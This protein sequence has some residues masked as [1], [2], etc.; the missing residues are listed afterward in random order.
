[1]LL[2]ELVLE[3]QS[4]RPA[5]LEKPKAMQLAAHSRSHSHLVARVLA[6]EKDNSK[7]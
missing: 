4:L 7:E 1:M 2:L 3:S 6:V 5:R